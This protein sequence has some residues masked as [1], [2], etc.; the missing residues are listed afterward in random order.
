M[1]PHTRAY[2]IKRM[3]ARSVTLELHQK[4][5]ANKNADSGL[6]NGRSFGVRR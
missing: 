1:I 4:R 5:A 2:I 3:T 6:V